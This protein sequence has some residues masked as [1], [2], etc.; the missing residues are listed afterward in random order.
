LTKGCR[1]DW[2]GAGGGR[3]S[4]RKSQLVWTCFSG[5]VV[6]TARMTVLKKGAE[7]MM[8]GDS[9]MAVMVY[10]VIVFRMCHVCTYV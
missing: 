2:R 9:E 4:G 1:P 6:L 10:G 7:R 8:V 5:V 3:V